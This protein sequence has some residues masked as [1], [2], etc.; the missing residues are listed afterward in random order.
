MTFKQIKS[1]GTLVLLCMLTNTVIAQRSEFRWAQYIM[2]YFD[3]ALRDRAEIVV[4]SDGN[5]YI[6]TPTYQWDMWRDYSY[7]DEAYDNDSCACERNQIIAKLDTAGNPVWVKSLRTNLMGGSG[8][9]RPASMAFDNLYLRDSLLYFSV[10]FSG[11][12]NKFNTCREYIWFFDTLYIDPMIRDY[13]TNNYY[14]PDSLQG[15]PFNGYNHSVFSASVIMDLDGNVIERHPYWCSLRAMSH[16]PGR[17]ITYTHFC[18]PAT[19]K[20]GPSIMDSQ[21][22]THL[23]FPLPI[24][25][26]D[27]YLTYL[28]SSLITE[29]DSV[30]IWLPPV[31]DRDDSLSLWVHIIIDSNQHITSVRRMVQDVDR[32]LSQTIDPLGYKWMWVDFDIKGISVDEE[33][34][35]YLTANCIAPFWDWRQRWL[36]GIQYQDST[37]E[38]HPYPYKPLIE[39]PYHI[40]L[41]SVHYITVENLAH[42][43]CTPIIIKYDPEGNILWCNQLYEEYED[44]IKVV[45]IGTLEGAP[46]IDSSYVYVRQ[47][48]MNL[49]YGIYDYYRIPLP[50][51]AQWIEDT[52]LPK[53]YYLDSAHT[54]RLMLPEID[55]PDSMYYYYMR[56]YNFGG[57]SGY[58]T[59]RTIYNSP[60]FIAYDRATG[61][62]VKAVYPLQDRFETDKTT[63]TRSYSLASNVKPEIYRDGKILMVTQLNY[64]NRSPRHSWRDQMYLLDN[65]LI[66]VDVN[67]NHTETIDSTLYLYL[68]NY[69]INGLS[70]DGRFICETTKPAG[71]TPPTTIPPNVEGSA[72]ILF[73]YYLPE[74]DKRRLEPCPP[75]ENTAL[76]YRNDFTAELTWRHDSAHYTYQVAQLTA[77]GTETPPDSAAWEEA[78]VTETADTALTLTLDTCVWLRVRGI[79]SEDNPGL[80]CEAVMACPQVGTTPAQPTPGIILMPNPSNDAVVVADSWSETPRHDVKE[81]QVISPLGHTVLY[82][83]GSARFNVSSLPAATYFVKVVTRHGTYLQKL[84]VE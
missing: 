55:E 45:E 56:G 21:K 27:E 35:I 32:P 50:P 76:T 39:F 40:F 25:T 30:V 23:F 36:N 29:N 46:L 60:Y 3:A 20:G 61:E 19:G 65:R 57:D 81:V 16:P 37:G 15:F 41:D 28:E 31:T 24:A 8:S 84:V 18:S 64:A 66:E 47:E 38:L 1:I 11:D 44:T 17:P 63:H 6:A 62:A 48:Q 12:N 82:T 5:T 52:L 77:D 13:R 7:V 34:N 72:P 71:G 10:G 49:Y 74:Y 83:K 75:V 2:G 78:F 58:W 51:T 54:Q 68:G 14:L 43:S 42:S 80:W 53:Y 59:Y 73:S 26:S 9:Y 33:D 67:T 69:N 70:D 4:D 79:C 22:N